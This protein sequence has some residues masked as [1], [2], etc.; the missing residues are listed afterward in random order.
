MRAD[1]MIEGALNYRLTRH[2]LSYWELP[3]PAV[4]RCVDTV[5]RRIRDLCV[6][7]SVGLFAAM[8]RKN[9][10]SYRHQTW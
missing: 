1:P 2:S 9:D 8:Q 4:G 6:C 7:L 10:L 3:T 5:I